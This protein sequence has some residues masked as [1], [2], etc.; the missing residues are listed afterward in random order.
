LCDNPPWETGLYKHILQKG[1][2]ER[3]RAKLE[4]ILFAER[5]DGKR[6]KHARNVLKMLYPFEKS[7]SPS[8]Y[9]SNI[10]SMRAAHDP[11]T[12]IIICNVKKT[13]Q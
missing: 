9:L 2:A 7:K 11:S 1:K 4:T 13:P 12:L 5:L 10:S 6:T 8:P 3:L